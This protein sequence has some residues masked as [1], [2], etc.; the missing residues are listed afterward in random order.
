LHVCKWA[1]SIHGIKAVCG[2]TFADPGALQEHL[3]ASHMSTVNGAKGNGYY[4]CWE[5]CHRPDEPFSQKSKL[6]GHFL[7]HSNCTFLHTI[8]CT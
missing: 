5:G 2:A 6:Q 1:A 7:T 3:I 8:A 4:C